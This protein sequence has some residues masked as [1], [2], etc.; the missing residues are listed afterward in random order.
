MPAA[1]PTVR[2]R[3][4]ITHLQ[5]AWDV[6]RVA[7]APGDPMPSP[8]R[9]PAKAAPPAEDARVGVGQGVAQLEVHSVSEQPRNAPH[10]AA[11]LVAGT[12]RGV[13]DLQCGGA[14]AHTAHT[15]SLGQQQ[16]GIVGC[17]HQLLVA[18]RGARQDGGGVHGC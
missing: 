6:H 12:P 2:R 18:G 16:A 15:V 14:E 10:G 13:V 7:A 1:L 17:T 9:P 3:E 8:G 5:E 4:T 11:G